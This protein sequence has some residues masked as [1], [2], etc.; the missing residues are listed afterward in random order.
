MS[1][2]ARRSIHAVHRPLAVGAALAVA[3][4]SG[5]AGC[6]KL[7]DRSA[8]AAA[9]MAPAPQDAKAAGLPG[10]TGA[11]RA[12]DPQRALR[13][14]VET[15][16]VVD[17]VAAAARSIRDV[18]A[19]SGG[20]VGVAHASS[21]GGSSSAYFELHVPSTKLAEL[22][23]AVGKLGEV[24]SDGEKAE[25]VTEQ[26]ADLD[27]R[28]RNAHAQEK[29]LLELLGDR[30][31]ALAD[32]VTV[33]KEIAGVRETIERM[34]AQ[35]RVL[36]GQIAFATVKV[37]LSSRADALVVVGPGHRVAGAVVDG[38]STA[39]SFLVGLAVVVASA[40]PTALLVAAIAY[41]LYRAGR[42]V[43][44]RRRAQPLA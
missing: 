27:A 8:P 12:A 20:Y 29:R 40:G 36:E 18:T 13:V 26:R 11:A 35:Q 7:A 41:G 22:R 30:T 21:N 15:S 9:A 38:V 3:L 19:S 23:S 10:A 4:L 14:T 28:V 1:A 6:G 33:E 42:R 32:V 17:D 39:G 2:L 25:D 16:V 5:A 34:E 43:V 31:G 44:R 24:T 37:S